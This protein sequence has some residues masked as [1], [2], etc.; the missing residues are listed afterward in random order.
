MIHK[1]PNFGQEAIETPEMWQNS[2]IQ[3]SEMLKG[4]RCKN[5]L[6]IK[7][8]TVVVKTTVPLHH[9]PTDEIYYLK[10]YMTY[11]YIHI[12]RRCCTYS[13]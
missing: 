8:D 1:P 2:S 13:K 7:P 12:D 5:L 9:G 6:I 11:K 4:N 10:A 3:T